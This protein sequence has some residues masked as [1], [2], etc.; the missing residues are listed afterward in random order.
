MSPAIVAR[1][2][3]LWAGAQGHRRERQFLLQF[4][5]RAR[6]TALRHSIRERQFATRGLRRLGSWN[7][8]DRSDLQLSANRQ[9]LLG[10]QPVADQGGGLV[11]GVTEADP[12][13]D[14]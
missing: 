14:R 2:R 11:T 7:G 9:S 8:R 3:C 12:G 4:P 1:A 5:G 13:G 10:P 6:R